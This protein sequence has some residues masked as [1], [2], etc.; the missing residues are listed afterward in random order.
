LI[1]L[2]VIWA[3]TLITG[4]V[5]ELEKTTG[6]AS[7]FLKLLNRRPKIDNEIGEAPDKIEG[8]IEFRNVS[9]RYPTRPNKTA[10]C[11]LNFRFYLV[12]Y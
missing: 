5:P 11:Y 9:F 3:A 8:K 1:S 10:H 6:S 12:I 4:A 2:E 7:A